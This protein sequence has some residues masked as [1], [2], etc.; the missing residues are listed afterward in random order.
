MSIGTG[1]NATKSAS[2]AD[3]VCGVVGADAAKPSKLS[4]SRVEA[5]VAV[6]AQLEAAAV[7]MAQ[8]AKDKRR[9]ARAHFV[10]LCVVAALKRKSYAAEGKIEEFYAS[11]PFG[12]KKG[13]VNRMANIGDGLRSLKGDVFTAVNIDFLDLDQKKMEERV[14]E[15]NGQEPRRKAPNRKRNLTAAARRV[16]QINEFIEPFPD[17][18]GEVTQDFLDAIAA[19]DGSATTAA[20]EWV[21]LLC[22]REP[23]LRKRFMDA[24]E[25]E[26]P[27]A[28]KAMPA[29]PLSSG[30]TA[31]SGDK[32]E[33]ANGEG[34]DDMHSAE[35]GAN[36][37]QTA[38]SLAAADPGTES[39]PS[40]QPKP[41]NKRKASPKP[42]AKGVPDHEPESRRAAGSGPH[43]A[44]SKEVRDRATTTCALS[45]AAASETTVGD[46]AACT[47]DDD[48]EVARVQRVIDA[49]GA[50]GIAEAE[51]A[52]AA[53]IPADRIK[54]VTKMAGAVHIS[55]R[56]GES[57][58]VSGRFR[59]KLPT[60]EPGKQDQPTVDFSQTALQGGRPGQCG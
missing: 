53:G 48:D 1:T 46:G 50:S 16:R 35:P 5:M 17:A 44:A 23:A 43:V 14:R 13:A 30:A 25:R 58:W 19:V 7:A 24:A 15:L 18:A 36:S 41:K 8:G 11:K 2:L 33:P 40:V 47:S 3:Y 59:R 37:R 38:K 10:V 27:R 55:D 32:E 20:V 51:L 34:D 56:S 26:W 12:K 28:D 54:R 21:V 52:K 9:E 6:F 4:Q 39:K 29:A 45:P 57:R 22:K 49:R 31:A 42:K 60:V